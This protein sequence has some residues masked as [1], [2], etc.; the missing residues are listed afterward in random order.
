MRTFY[1]FTIILFTAIFTIAGCNSNNSQVDTTTTIT[2]STT[3]ANSSNELKP[4]GAVPEWAPSI[5][6]EMQVVIEKLIRLG[7]QPIETIGAVEA[8]LQPTPTDAV[9][10]VIKEK[11]IT[12]PAPLCDT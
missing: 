7:G 5:K 11:N 10:A 6:P 3:L 4:V 9:M 2:D 12:M 8:R 1:S